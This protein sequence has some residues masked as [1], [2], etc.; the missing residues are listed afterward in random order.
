MRLCSPVARCA[1]D[2]IQGSD[3]WPHPF[4]GSSHLQRGSDHP[5][6]GP[7]AA[8]VSGRRG[9]RRRRILGGHLRQRRLEGSVAVAADGARDGRAPLQGPDALPQLRPSDGDHGGARSRERRRGGGDGR[10]SAGPAGGGEPDAGQVARRVR[11]R[12]RHS[13]APAR[14]DRVQEAHRRPLLPPA[15][16]A[17]RAARRSRSTRATF[18]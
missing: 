4:V 8:R 2:D 17:A 16:R 7:P 9:E 11:R 12:V 15:A 5:R 14:R 18:G 10:R 1:R 3:G 13:L 6:A